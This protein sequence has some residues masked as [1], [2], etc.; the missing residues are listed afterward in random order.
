MTDI[1]IIVFK[2]RKINDKPYGKNNNNFVIILYQKTKKHHILNQKE[3]T[4]N[5]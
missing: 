1:S 3:K 2:I 4:V 5:Y